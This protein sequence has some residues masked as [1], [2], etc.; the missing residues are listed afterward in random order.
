MTPCCSIKLI[1]EVSTTYGATYGQIINRKKTKFHVRAMTTQR[2]GTIQTWLAF[3]Q[4]QISFS[5]T[6]C[7]IFK[8]NPKVINFQRISHKIRTK[9]A[10]WNMTL[11]SIMGKVQLI[12]FIVQ[13]MLAYYSHIYMC[14]TKVLS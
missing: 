10:S 14:L 1:R 12:K 6:E 5:Y 7:P 2:A 13:S 3:Q 9:L 8:G 11:L 4:G